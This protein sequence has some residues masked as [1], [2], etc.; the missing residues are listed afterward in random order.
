MGAVLHITP[1]DD[2]VAGEPSS[3]V[4]DIQ[5]KAI[6][7]ERYSFTLQIFNS[8]DT[9]QVVPTS[10]SGPVISANYIFP[11]AGLYRI[12]LRADPVE[13]DKQPLTFTHN[14]LISRGLAS[15]KSLSPKSEIAEV[16][17]IASSCGL[18][19]LGIIFWN[20]RAAMKK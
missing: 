8:S 17:L 15:A 2:P 11:A 9:P 12:E 4:F 7:S 13:T 19:I 18:I 3:L 14:Q 16:G 5:D 10:I 6:T 20:N 1:D